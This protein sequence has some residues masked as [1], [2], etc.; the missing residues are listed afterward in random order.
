MIDRRVFLKGIVGAGITSDLL[1]GRKL[2]VTSTDRSKF[3][4]QLQSPE[5]TLV[6]KVD[7]VTVHEKTAW[8]VD[9][10][11]MSYDIQFEVYGRCLICFEPVPICVSFFTDADKKPSPNPGDFNVGSIYLMTGE[12]FLYEDYFELTMP[13]FKQIESV[14]TRQEIDEL[15][16]CFGA[17][18]ATQSNELAV[19]QPEGK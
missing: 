4:D 18:N 11:V 9:D 17:V 14:L 12:M 5:L 19:H 16:R 2:N 3:V 1:R 8:V 6:V 10:V 7:E 15:L 13:K